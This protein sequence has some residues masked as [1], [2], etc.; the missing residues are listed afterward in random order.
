MT[1]EHLRVTCTDDIRSHTTHIRMTYEYTRI[2]QVCHTST[3][4]SHTD[5][6]RLNASDIRVHKNDKQITYR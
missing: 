3:C 6:I 5:G 4:N 1:Y 2:K